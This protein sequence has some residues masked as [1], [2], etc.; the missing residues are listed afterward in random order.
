MLQIIKICFCSITTKTSSVIFNVFII[1]FCFFFL[2]CLWGYFPPNHK[3]WTTVGLLLDFTELGRYVFC[4]EIYC[5]VG[6]ICCNAMYEEILRVY[7]YLT[8]ILCKGFLG[9]SP[10]Q[11]FM[12]SLHLN[13]SLVMITLSSCPLTAFTDSQM[14]PLYQEDS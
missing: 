1:C 3:F 8:S 6:K 9:S 13:F 12:C 11:N 7:Q 5:E 14:D 4:N 10:F 2:I